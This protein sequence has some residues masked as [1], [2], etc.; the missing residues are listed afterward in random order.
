MLAL[1]SVTTRLLNQINRHI[2]RTI[3]PSPMVFHE[4]LAADLRLDLHVIPPQPDGASAAHPR[5]RDFFTIVTSTVANNPL[6]QPRGAHE[7]RQRA[8]FMITLPA[9]WPGLRRDGTFVPEL[10]RDETFWWPIR[11]LKKIAHQQ[12]ESNTGICAG[13]IIPNGTPATPFAKNV[14]F[15]GFIALPSTFHPRAAEMVAHDDLAITF[16]ALWPIYPAE[17]RLAMTEGTQALVDAF[18]RSGVGGMINLLRRSAV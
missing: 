10:M 16:H 18:K 6:S 15:T 7:R 4:T 11:W 5:G 8:E 2:D 1:S 13:E 3:G 12:H 17:M 14:P 9:G